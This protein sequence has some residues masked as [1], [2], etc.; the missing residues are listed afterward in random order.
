MTLAETADSPRW[1]IA[2]DLLR[3][4]A[5]AAPISRFGSTAPTPTTWRCSI[6]CTPN[7]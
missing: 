6:S 1:Q 2:S 5:W 4:P 3:G 7:W